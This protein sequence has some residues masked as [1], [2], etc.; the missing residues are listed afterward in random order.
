MKRTLVLLLAGA[1]TADPTD[2]PNEGRAGVCFGAGELVGVMTSARFSRPADD[3]TVHGFDLDGATLPIGVQ[4]IAPA[5]REDWA[6][7]V[8]RYLE[9]TGACR[10][11]V[12][13]P[14]GRDG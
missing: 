13:R 10:A 5:W 4:V 12:A 6:L 8:A 3:G 11:P 2:D 14:E 1:C 7:R 9:A